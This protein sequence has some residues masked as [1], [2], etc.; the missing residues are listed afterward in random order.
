MTLAETETETFAPLT[1]STSFEFIEGVFRAY[2]WSPFN[3]FEIITDVFIWCE[4][5]H[6]FRKLRVNSIRGGSVHGR[7][8]FACR[9]PISGLI[10]V[11][12]QLI[13]T[14]A[15]IVVNMS[16]ELRQPQVINWTRFLI[17]TWVTTTLEY[18]VNWKYRTFH[19]IRLPLR[20]L[21]FWKRLFR[22]SQ[23]Q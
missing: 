21:V 9:W 8:N 14:V 16:G 3:F 13:Q 22:S 15:I 19:L 2:M 20:A 11:L 17:S 10:L 5:C 4:L 12:A 7:S 1:A 6:I 23:I 18:G